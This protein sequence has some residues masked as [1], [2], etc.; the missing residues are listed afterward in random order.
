MQTKLSIFREEFREI[1]KC[2]IGENKGS[3]FS[4]CYQKNK[5]CTFL[6][7]CNQMTKVERVVILMRTEEETGSNRLRIFRENFEEIIRCKILQNKK[8]QII[9]DNCFLKKIKCPF[10]GFC[11]Q[12]AKTKTNIIEIIMQKQKEGITIPF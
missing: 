9:F 11:N 1:V 5:D 3:I 12:I 6:S 8:E 4:G 2:K 10:F 7:F